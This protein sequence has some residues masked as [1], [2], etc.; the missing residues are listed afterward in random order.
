MSLCF[1]CG[2]D[3]LADAIDNV[4]L[5]LPFGFGWRIAG[6]RRIYVALAG[7][8]LTLSVETLQLR[9]VVGRDPSIRDI[10]MNTIG[11]LIGIA[12]A[13][14]TRSL[15][16]PSPRRARVLYRASLVTWI[17]LVLAGGIFLAPDYHASRC[18]VD[19]APTDGD[20]DWFH[21]HLIRASLN[22]RALSPGEEVTSRCSVMS[23]QQPNAAQL[24]A[25]IV[26]GA[27]TFEGSTIVGLHDDDGDLLA[28]SQNGTAL[29][30]DLRTRAIGWRLRSPI[31]RIPHGA[32]IDD[33][34]SARTTLRL[35]GRVSRDNLRLISSTGM[36]SA[37]TQLTLSPF[38]LW[39]TVLPSNLVTSTHAGVMTLLYC[40][41]VLFPV[42][43]YGG[44]TFDGQS[45]T[46]HRVVGE[47]LLAVVIVV[48]VPLAVG[49]TLAPGS[50][51]IG[52]ACG[53]VAGGVAAAAYRRWARRSVS[54]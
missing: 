14:Y 25:D 1:L 6:G 5:F 31:V 51:W 37:A 13:Q 30:L 2:S 46:G 53:I 9:A 23:L 45:T 21:G 20:G 39:A 36:R 34:N 7:F 24:V 28:L 49:Y 3:A 16:H 27:P 15:V 35:E 17:L 22:G 48:A 12:L 43:Y 33:A 8:A 11:T 50:I 19:W 18:F 41:A 4:I 26:P 40:F 44:W 10:A 29:T 42:G 32:S 52:C 47:L 38:L 54:R